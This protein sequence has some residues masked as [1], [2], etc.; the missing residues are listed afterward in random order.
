MGNRDGEEMSL[1]S[2]RG[3]PRG[4]FFVAGMGS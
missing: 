2:V 3:D 1:A 4:I